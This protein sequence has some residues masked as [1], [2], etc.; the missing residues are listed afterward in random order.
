MKRFRVSIV[1]ALVVLACVIGGGAAA[2]TASAANCIPSNA[3]ATQVSGSGPYAVLGYN[4]QL[5]CTGVEGVRFYHDC[6]AQGCGSQS[7][8][9]DY[10]AANWENGRMGS[11]TNLGLQGGG[12]SGN[13]TGYTEEDLPGHSE[14]RP[15]GQGVWFYQY[16]NVWFWG[17]CRATSKNFWFQI[18]NT[19]THTWGGLA[20]FFPGYYTNICVGA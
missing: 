2:S 10:A 11:C 17:A 6:Y 3:Y 4:A 8:W 12:C 16:S 19:A 13:S 5:L 9:Y 18:K 14:Q 20:E 7:G 15:Y 1:G